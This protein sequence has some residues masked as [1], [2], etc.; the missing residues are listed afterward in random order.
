MIF[1]NQIPLQDLIFLLFLSMVKTLIVDDE[2]HA[3]ENLEM[4]IQIYGGGFFHIVG[5]CAS[6][7]SAINLIIQKKPDLVF[8][9]MTLSR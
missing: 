9:D 3:Q 4:L 2:I 8:L 7:E 5:K 6:V 1:C